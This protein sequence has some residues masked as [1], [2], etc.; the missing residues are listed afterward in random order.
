ME[1]TFICPCC[2]NKFKA[3]LQSIM[4]CNKCKFVF[5]YNVD[6]IKEQDNKGDNKGDN[7]D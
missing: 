2:K 4:M 6:I 3:K 1:K 7:N 5:S